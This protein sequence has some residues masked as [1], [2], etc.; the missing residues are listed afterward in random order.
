M[1]IV[2]FAV[3]IVFS[4][5]VDAQQREKIPKVGYLSNSSSEAPGDSAFTQGLRDLGWVDGRTILGRCR[6]RG[7]NS[8]R[9]GP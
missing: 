4:P 3:G 8:A 2:A 7:Q 9:H 5:G 1:L 6:A